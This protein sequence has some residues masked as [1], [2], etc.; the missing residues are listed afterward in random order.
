MTLT[1]DSSKTTDVASETDVGGDVVVAAAFEYEI[2]QLVSPAVRLVDRCWAFDCHHQVEQD[3]SD[4]AAVVV[5]D[6]QCCCR[7]PSLVDCCACYYKTLEIPCGFY[8]EEKLNSSLCC[9]YYHHR[10]DDDE[11]FVVGYDDDYDHRQ[12][13]S[14]FVRPNRVVA[15]DHHETL[16]CGEIE[17]WDYR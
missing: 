14:F 3:S 9:F 6:D 12:C 1:L 2:V 8:V 10:C 4:A 17:M 11:A 15:D 5:V 7:F 13:P 16:N